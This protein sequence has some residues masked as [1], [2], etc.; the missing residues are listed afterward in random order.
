MSFDRGTSSTKLR[1]RQNWTWELVLGSLGGLASFIAGFS[2]IFILEVIFFFT[3]RFA[4][5]RSK[6]HQFRDDDD[7]DDDALHWV[8]NQHHINEILERRASDSDLVMA[9]ALFDR[10]EKPDKE[11]ID[12]MMASNG[13]VAKRTGTKTTSARMR[14]KTANSRV[15]SGLSVSR[16]KIFPMPEEKLNVED[17]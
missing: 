4:D 17:I 5:N 6:L 3:V 12:K 1:R 11:V 7:E 13:G 2:L 8:K 9:S 14:P 16:R 10:Q 15:N